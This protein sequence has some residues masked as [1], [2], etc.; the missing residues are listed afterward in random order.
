MLKKTVLAGLAALTLG[1]GLSASATSAQAQVFYGPYYGPRYGYYHRHYH[2]GAI[3]AGIVG[4][5]A[6]GA[7]AAAAAQPAYVAPVYGDCWV[8]RRRVVN[9]WGGVA[10]RRVRVCN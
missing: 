9:A 5:L 4:G 8:E 2:G 3:A 7:I 6:L 10:V 1:A